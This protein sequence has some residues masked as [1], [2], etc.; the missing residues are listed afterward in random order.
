MVNF[1]EIE[2]NILP[3]FTEIERNNC[4]AHTHEIVSSTLALNVD[5][6][7]RKPFKID[8]IDISQHFT[9]A[10]LF[11]LDRALLT[12]REVNNAQFSEIANQ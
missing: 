5:I 12:P 2:V 8:L 10:I 6:C 4:L 3:A 9:S 7:R 11:C 1:F